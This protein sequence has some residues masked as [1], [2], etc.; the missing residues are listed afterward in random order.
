MIVDFVTNY[1]NTQFLDIE[2]LVTALS[3]LITALVGILVFFSNPK[4]WTNRLFAVLA[5]IFD[6]Y[7]IVNYFSLHPPILTPESRLAWIRWDMFIVAFKTPFLYLFVHTFPNNKIV[8]QKKYLIAVLAVMGTVAILSL[9]PLVFQEIAFKNNAPI[10]VPGPAIPL[11]GLNFAGF[12]I[13]S[14][15]VLVKK[16]RSATGEDRMSL[17]YL[18]YGIIVSFSLF[19]TAILASVVL[20]QVS[21]FVF[22]APLFLAL[23]MVPVAYSVLRHNLFNV[24]VIAANIFVVVLLIVL[25]SKLIASQTPTEGITNSIV[26]LLSIIFGVLIIRAIKK[27]VEQRE[28]IE[29]LARDLTKANSKLRELDR[30]KSEFVSIASHQLRSPLTAV[31]GYASLILEG[32]FGKLP[33]G[34]MEAVRRIADSGHQMVYAVED[35]L[36]VSRIE[37]GRMKYE[38]NLFD[39]SASTDAIVKELLP[40]AQKKG[41][42][43]TYE[44]KKGEKYTVKGD[45]GKIRQVIANIVDNC[46]KYTPKG[47]I[48][49]T[50]ARTSDKKL[51]ITTTDTGVGMS[52]KT[53][54]ILFN[55][56]V[57]AENASRV[58]VGGTGLGLF[59]AK[60]FVDAHNGR[61]WA[62]SAGE[63]KGSS[64]FIELTGA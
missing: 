18:L 21:S 64:F 14:I 17:A 39:L 1:W 61:I 35:F 12:L 16:R 23:L 29:I 62:E 45:E 15:L 41:L 47:S 32:S 37:Q 52:K 34:A 24:K 3:F 19:G 25:L 48:H 63:G 54:E 6:I 11:V 22:L 46:I 20:L 27:E 60:Q 10:P 2:V 7:T 51:L 31:R 26:F 13:L 44:A 4:S 58:N 9:T 59:V 33:E 5:L 38:M 53:L 49:V 55:K 8:L 36:N 40:V 42:M 28:Y 57:R 50:L 30:Q 56:Y 43:L